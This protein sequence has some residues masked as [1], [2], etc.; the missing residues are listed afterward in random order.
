M[1]NQV[2][3]LNTVV[4]DYINIK[5]TTFDFYIQL[6]LVAAVTMDTAQQIQGKIKNRILEKKENFIRKSKLFEN[7]LIFN[8]SEKNIRKKSFEV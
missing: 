2:V 3:C 6:S 1:L 8:F 4:G 7:L 5:K